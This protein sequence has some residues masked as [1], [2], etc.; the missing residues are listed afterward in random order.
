MN[1]YQ[2]FGSDDSSYVPRIVEAPPP[3]FH[4][5]SKLVLLLVLKKLKINFKKEITCLLDCLTFRLFSRVEHGPK[6]IQDFR[7]LFVIGSPMGCASG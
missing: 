7:R 5:R 6:I 1:D 3:I 4:K 2:P